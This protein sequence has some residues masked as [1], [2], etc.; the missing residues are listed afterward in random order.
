MNPQLQELI[1]Y[2]KKAREARQSDQ[3]TKQILLKNGWSDAEVNEAFQQQE[4]PQPQPQ[5]QA[6]P[7]QTQP[8]QTQVSGQ[9]KIQV[10]PQ[11][12]SAENKKTK[13][14]LFI[15]LFV[16]AVVA[17]FVIFAVYVFL[18]FQ[19]QTIVITPTQTPA[20][21]NQTASQENAPAISPELQQVN[22][23]LGQIGAVAKSYFDTT[24]SYGILCKSNNVLNSSLENYGSQLIALV[25]D[26]VRQGAVKSICYSDDQN[27][28]FSTQLA[29]GTFHCISADNVVGSV[30]CTSAETLCE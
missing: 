23:D 26:I 17:V 15:I 27:F 3:Q 25:R 28:C 20:Q 10:N 13:T 21:N 22:F 2:I 24:E 18:S 1:D 9:P 4:K 7:Q 14:S 29:D 12:Q 6:Q 8:A 30:E 5:P 11:V 19:Q 16:V